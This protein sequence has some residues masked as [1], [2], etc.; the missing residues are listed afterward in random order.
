MN[1]FD[2][3][4]LADYNAKRANVLTNPLDHVLK[5]K[6]VKKPVQAKPER[7]E[8]KLEHDFEALWK[9]LDGPPLER[10]FRFNPERRWKFDFCVLSCNIAIEIEGGQ[11]GVGKPCPACRRRQMGG[12]HTVKGFQDNCIKYNSA[13]FLG[14]RVIRLTASMVDPV[15]LIPIIEMC[16]KQTKMLEELGI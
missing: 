4:W 13:A 6:G 7:K 11:F 3:K 2:S 14:W 9:R 5:G 16:K 8:S 12:H 1:H 15:Y 10:E